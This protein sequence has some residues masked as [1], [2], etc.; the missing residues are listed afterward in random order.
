MIYTDPTAAAPAIAAELERAGRILLL[1]HIN[2]DGDAIGSMLGLRHALRDL[3]KTPIAL[4]SSD[5]P[6]YAETLPGIEHVQVYTP[7][8]ALPE[9]D[10][11]WM[12]DTASLERV[13]PVHTEH[14]EH[15]RA[16]P[17]VIVDHHVTN[18]G[19]GRVNLIMSQAASTAEVLYLLLRA[20]EAPISPE[21]A[22]CLLLGLTTDT[23]SFQTNSTNPQSLHVAAELLKAGAQ[24]R[25]V[26]DAVYYATPYSTVQLIGQ[27]LS[28]IERDGALIWTYV[29]QEMLRQ[30]GAED[31]ASDD[32]VQVMQRVAGVRACI[33]FKERAGGD[34]KISLRSSPGIDVAAIAKTWG[35]GGHTQA[36][37]ATLAMDLD[38]ARREV[39]PA[40]QSALAEKP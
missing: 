19:A 32:V 35:G 37:G 18:D 17:L 2:P 26:V 25:A 15:L 22:T 3:G 38:A 7:G 30:T 39:I 28:R 23:Q 27:A 4:A 10:L 21:A 31:E 24:H 20:L 13:G 11:I 14:A 36:A 9:A 33:L 8:T 1:S 5:I 12:V 29:S 16:Q 34:I 40:V 6:S